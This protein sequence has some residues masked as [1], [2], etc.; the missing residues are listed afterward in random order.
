VK[1]LIG[2][3]SVMLVFSVFVFAQ[4][5]EEGGAQARG[6]AQTRSAAPAR[7]AAPARGGG[8]E[9]GGGYVPPRGPAPARPQRPTAIPKH[10]QDSAPAQR[11]EPAQ[12]RTYSDMPQH[13]EAPHVHSNGQWIGHDTGKNDP[14]MHLDHPWEHG[15]FSGGIGPSY[16]YR[17]EGGARDRFRFHGF[18][19]SVFEGDYGYCDNW[20][21]DSDDI[22]IYDDPD[23]LGWYLA[24]NVRLGTYVH[25][26]FLG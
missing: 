24:Y 5:K 14:R 21:W 23:H 7:A 16:V 3:I 10:A 20:L 13:P 8:H 26:M 17:L 12:N 11:P 2:L 9:V 6:G 15:R 18:Y 4:K 1:K 22:V 25:V 19:F